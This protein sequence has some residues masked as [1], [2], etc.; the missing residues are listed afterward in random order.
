MD[1]HAV[2]MVR[3]NGSACDLT[4]GR[5]QPS[6][7]QPE[8]ADIAACQGPRNGGA[9]RSYLVPCPPGHCQAATFHLYGHPTLWQ[10]PCVAIALPVPAF[11]G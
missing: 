3:M 5:A 6:P 8:A 4:Y 11:G 7:W 9:A 2:I 1:I 10:A